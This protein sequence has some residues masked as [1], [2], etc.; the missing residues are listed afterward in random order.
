[1]AGLK[2]KVS[3]AAI[4]TKW[5]VDQQFRIN[6]SQTKEK[7]LSGDIYQNKLALAEEVLKLFK[8]NDQFDPAINT[9]CENIDQ[10]QKD[11]IAQKEL[12]T[13][14]RAETAP[15]MFTDESA[16]MSTPVHENEQTSGLV[17]PNCGMPV[18]VRFCPDCGQEGVPINR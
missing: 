2:D 18:P 8:S 15:L 11:L 5:K 9:I 4:V 6:T 13:A 3:H 14:I 10:L 17:C 1:M 12:T 7:Q 16:P